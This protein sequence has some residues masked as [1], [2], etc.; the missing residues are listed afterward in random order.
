MAQAANA[1]QP[2][3]SAGCTDGQAGMFPGNIPNKKI[4]L[5]AKI[6]WFLKIKLMSVKSR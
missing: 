6:S 5:Y 2:V 3:F 4:I 1:I